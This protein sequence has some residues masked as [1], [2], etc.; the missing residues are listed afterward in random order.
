MRIGPGEFERFRR[1]RGTR[2]V[3][4]GESDDLGEGGRTDDDLSERERRKA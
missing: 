3:G 4:R 1:S 2:V